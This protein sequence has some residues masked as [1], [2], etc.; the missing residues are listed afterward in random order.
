MMASW[1]NRPTEV[2]N[3]LNPAFVGVLLRSAIDGY[4]EEVKA[5][6]PFELLFLVPPFCLHPATAERLPRSPS[7]T[8]LHVWLQRE[9]NRDVLLTFADRASALVPF[10]RE[11]LLFACERLILTVG[12]DGRLS[13]GSANLRGIT[14]YRSTSKEVREAIRL[15]EL[16]GKWFSL[17]GTTA[18]IFTLLGVRP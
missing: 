16:V 5:G 7:V 3:L 9:G 2:A 6:M 18:T 1:N 11:A 15:A 17:A 8:P 12:D 10:V 13:R 4:A 14:V